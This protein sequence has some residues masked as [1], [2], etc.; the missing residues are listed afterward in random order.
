MGT[1]SEDKQQPEFKGVV[2]KKT[3]S[4]PGSRTGS[5]SRL[6][7]G[8]RGEI[9]ASAT[10]L[11]KKVE[12]S[13]S[14]SASRRGS[15]TSETTAEFANVSLKKA[16]RVQGDQSK[17]EVEQVSLKPIP[18]GEGEE[19][20]VSS[21]SMGMRK[22]ERASS[23]TRQRVLRETKFEANDEEYHDIKSSLDRLKKKDA[24]PAQAL[25][26]EDDAAA[27]VRKAPKKPALAKDDAAAKPLA[28][29]RPKRLAREEEEAEKVQLKP[30][31]RQ[32]SSK[33]NTPAIDDDDD[34]EVARSLALRRSKRTAQEN[35]Q[36]EKVQL[37]QVNQENSS[38]DESITKDE[39]A[40]LPLAEKK[41]ENLTRQQ[42]AERIQPES[43]K[44]KKSSKDASPAEDDAAAKPVAYRRPKKLPKEEEDEKV[45]LKP[46]RRE[47]KTFTSSI[48]CLKKAT[49]EE[50]ER[51]EMKMKME[52]P[53]LLR[54]TSYTS[55]LDNIAIGGED[56]KQ[57]HLICFS[58]ENSGSTSEV[59]ENNKPPLLRKMSFTSSLDNIAIGSE[60]REKVHLSCFSKEMGSNVD[61][62]QVVPGTGR[63]Q[64]RSQARIQDRGK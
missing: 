29:R 10:S 48:E 2:L 9:S 3:G 18:V 61:L 22:E 58:K 47:K 1:A 55:S 57:V 19:T 64:A 4:K 49:E 20:T 38:K 8:S 14:L 32:K 31:D 53:V 63:R 42:D 46:I 30:M 41:Q 7:C 36:I 43:V 5:P 51:Q 13:S 25:S 56:Q 35:E 50:E 40:I 16:K 17:F 23:V 54:K 45:H 34:D 39:A 52:R 62:V 37:K 21:S 33:D 59:A 24:S 26:V 27:G 60:E 11:L 6:D 44:T 12:M 15:S 28:F